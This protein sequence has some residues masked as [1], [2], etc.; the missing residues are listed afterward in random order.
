MYVLK[1]YIYVCKLFAPCI[2]NIFLLNLRKGQIMY[3]IDGPEMLEPDMCVQC[4]HGMCMLHVSVSRNGY[5]L[6]GYTYF[7]SVYM[8]D[9]VTF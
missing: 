7:V 4:V 3:C 8:K 2:L 5:V 6:L 9:I 1:T